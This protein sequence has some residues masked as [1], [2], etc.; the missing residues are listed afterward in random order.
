MNCNVMTYNQFNNLSDLHVKHYHRRN[1]KRNR[2]TCLDKQ[3]IYF[4]IVQSTQGT[5]L[6]QVTIN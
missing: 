6:I 3:F 5:S 2:Y 4:T 1:K